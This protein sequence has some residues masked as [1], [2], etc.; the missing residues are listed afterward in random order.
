M[1]DAS[2]EDMKWIIVVRLGKKIK[3]KK[4][5]M[6]KSSLDIRVR[7]LLKTGKKKKANAV[8]GSL[9]TARKYRVFDCALAFSRN[10]TL[11]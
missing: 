2:S 11:I 9:F 3:N 4:C 1:L 7:W 6:L 5:R 10:G 8:Q